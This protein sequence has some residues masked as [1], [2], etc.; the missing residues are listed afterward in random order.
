MEGKATD[1][2]LIRPT[3]EKPF[4]RQCMICFCI[5]AVIIGIAI[6]IIIWQTWPRQNV[7][8][9]FGQNGITNRGRIKIFLERRSKQISNT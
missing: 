8:R 3:R 1:K 5:A 4:T 2:T 7:K 6:G 9:R